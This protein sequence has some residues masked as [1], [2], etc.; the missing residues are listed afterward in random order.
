MLGIEMKLAAKQS[1][2]WRISQANGIPRVKQS[3]H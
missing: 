1:G 3:E 2:S